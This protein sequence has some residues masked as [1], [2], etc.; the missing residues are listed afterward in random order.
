MYLSLIFN[1]FLPIKKF[2]T[3]S[4]YPSGSGPFS[5][6]NGCTKIPLDK[7]VVWKNGSLKWLCYPSQCGGQ[8]REHV[9]PGHLCPYPG[10][11][12]LVGVPSTEEKN[13]FQ[14]VLYMTVSNQNK[15]FY[16][17]HLSAYV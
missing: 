2:Y 17:L 9:R 8:Q 14:S 5:Y 4:K 7:D 15:E 10:Y 3:K 1:F 11:G 16:R 6:H 13:I 12:E